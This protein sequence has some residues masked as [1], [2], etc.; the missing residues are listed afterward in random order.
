MVL[1]L[2]LAG[3]PSSPN[4]TGRIEMA[5]ECKAQVMCK[6]WWSSSVFYNLSSGNA[7]KME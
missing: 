4:I 6:K 2:D 3:C 7:I 5:E 1:V